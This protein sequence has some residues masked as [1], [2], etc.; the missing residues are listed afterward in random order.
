MPEAVSQGYSVFITADHGNAERM[1]GELETSHTVSKVPFIII[2]GDKLKKKR[3][4]LANVAPTILKQMG[5]K[6]PREMT[7]AMT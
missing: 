1:G 4:S 3:F 6:I 5:L 2:R 7:E